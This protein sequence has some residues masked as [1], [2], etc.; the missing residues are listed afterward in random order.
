M[1]RL[2]ILSQVEELLEEQG[3]AVAAQTPVWVQGEPVYASLY[4][5]DEDS[6]WW[7][8][9]F[10]RQEFF[11]GDVELYLSPREEA[12]DLKGCWLLGDVEALREEEG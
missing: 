4:F 3:G 9:L 6:G 1:A 12:P 5:Q 2:H 7:K 8:V 11:D 10:R